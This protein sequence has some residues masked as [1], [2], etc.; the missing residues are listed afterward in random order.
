MPKQK[1]F[2]EYEALDKAKS[3]F[4]KK[5]FNGASMDELVQAT[6]LSRSSIYDTFGDKYTLYIRCLQRYSQQSQAMIDSQLEKMASPRKKIQAFFDYTIACKLS[7]PDAMGCFMVNATTEL[8]GE[9]TNIAKIS[10]TNM[11]EMEQ[12]FFLWVKEGQAMGEVN[13][14]YTPRAL[15]RHLYNS[16]TGIQVTAKTKPD[17]SVLKDIVKV[18][19]SVLD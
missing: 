16:L 19:L 4:N 10:C 17:K 14:A 3:L 11:Q 1:Q 15:A 18:A 13:P 6:G 2:D 5:G 9:D 8:A 12:R 7:D